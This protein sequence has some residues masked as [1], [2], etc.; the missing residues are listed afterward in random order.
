M[1]CLP[2]TPGPDREKG[3]NVGRRRRQPPAL[4]RCI[5]KLSHQALQ[6]LGK[7]LSFASAIVFHS[8]KGWDRSLSACMDVLQHQDA[9]KGLPASYEK[10]KQEIKPI[11]AQ[12]NERNSDSHDLKVLLIHLNLQEQLPHKALAQ[13]NLHTK[14]S[15]CVHVSHLRWIKC[16]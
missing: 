6:S 1:N 10:N 11:P 4:L 3:G 14:G 8:G 7:G 2:R 12:P 15:D 16:S 9:S 13:K 5:T